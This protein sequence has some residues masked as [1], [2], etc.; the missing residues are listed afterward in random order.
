MGQKNDGNNCICTVLMIAYNHRPYIRLAIE[1][2]ISQRTKYKFKVHIFDDASND[3]TSDI[4]REYAKHYP[5][6]IIPFIA[7][8]N[9]GDRKSVV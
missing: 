6:L 7:S 2:V 3:G 9:R 8:E 4:V 5:D 1:S